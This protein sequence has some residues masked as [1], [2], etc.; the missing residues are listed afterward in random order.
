[1]R[2]RR[3]KLQLL[4][5]HIDILLPCQFV[6]VYR[7]ERWL[8]EG[9]NYAAPSGQETNRL[10]ARRVNSKGGGGQGSCLVLHNIEAAAAFRRTLTFAPGNALIG[11]K[12]CRTSLRIG[13]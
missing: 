9:V 12:I 13:I 8:C 1:M 10:P 11:L 2:E 4:I 6:G 3:E 5:V 7:L